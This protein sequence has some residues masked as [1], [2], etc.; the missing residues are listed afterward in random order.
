M[1]RADKSKPVMH[2]SET[3]FHV[4]FVKKRRKMRADLSPISDDLQL[5]LCIEL[6]QTNRTA[7]ARLEFA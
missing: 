7:T 3:H 4:R 5:F 6:N 2:V 1:F